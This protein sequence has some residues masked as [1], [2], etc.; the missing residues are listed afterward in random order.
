MADLTPDEVAFFQTGELSPALAAPT[1]EP[2]V[3]TPET[4]VA[5]TISQP[6]AAD[7]LRQSLAEEQS[8][9]IQAELRLQQIQQQIQQAQTTVAAPDPNTDPLGAMMHQLNTVSTTV[10]GLQQQ[11]SNQSNQQSQLQN[12]QQFATGIQQLKAEFMKTTPDFQDAYNHLRANRSED[13]RILGAQPAQIDQ[14]LLQEEVSIASAALRDGKNPVE[15]IYNL[16]KRHGYTT[17]AVP[18]TT[19][20]KLASVAAGEAASKSL[21]RASAPTPEFTLDGLKEA[22]DSDL[23]KLVQD[24]DAWA[25]FTGGGEKDIFHSR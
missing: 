23:N 3:V 15:T 14:V 6:D 11:L 1:P 10:T 8:R 20:A 5:P 18:L 13:L 4:V 25:K 22:G 9:R 19:Q 24:P 17:K 7:L 16:A 2:A 21:A 12:F